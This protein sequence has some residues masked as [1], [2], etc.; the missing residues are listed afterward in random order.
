MLR[1]IATDL[2]GSDGMAVMTDFIFAADEDVYADFHERR[3]DASPTRR[4]PSTCIKAAF[5]R[6]ARYVVGIGNLL[7]AEVSRRRSCL[8]GTMIS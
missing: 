8:A 5:E 4:K 7:N 3:A 6:Q 2:M 1:L